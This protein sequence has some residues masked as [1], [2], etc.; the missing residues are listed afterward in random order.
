M[1]ALSRGKVDYEKE[2]KGNIRNSGNVPIPLWENWERGR[3]RVGTAARGRAFLKHGWRYNL[4]GEKEGTRMPFMLTLRGK[5]KVDKK[6]GSPQ[7]R[8]ERASLGKKTKGGG[9]RK[10]LLREER[11]NSICK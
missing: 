2:A 11:S 8:E 1:G 7:N 10:D 6:G 4:V 5:R 3:S 9:G